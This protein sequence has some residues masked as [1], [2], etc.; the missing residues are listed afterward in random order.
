MNWW[1]CYYLVQKSKFSSC[2]FGWSMYPIHVQCKCECVIISQMFTD[3]LLICLNIILSLLHNYLLKTQSTFSP[4]FHIP[5]GPLCCRARGGGVHN[6]AWWEMFQCFLC[7]AADNNLLFRE[8]S[9]RS[10]EIL[11]CWTRARYRSA[12]HALTP[13]SSDSRVCLFVW[14]PPNEPKVADSTAAPYAKGLPCYMT[15]HAGEKLRIISEI[16][17]FLVS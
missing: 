16:V 4:S 13:R 9:L 7:W 5:Q 6:G 17:Q 14:P 8:L 11:S 1:L 3:T 10:S 15:L 12:S 2:H